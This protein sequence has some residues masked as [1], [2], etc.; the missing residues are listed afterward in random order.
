M[1][2]VFR[3]S[4]VQDQ[5]Q[6][7]WSVAE[8]R[9][10]ALSAALMRW[11]SDNV[12]CERHRCLWQG[13]QRSALGLHASKLKTARCTWDCGY[14]YAV[15]SPHCRCPPPQLHDMNCLQ[16]SPAGGTSMSSVTA[17]CKA[18][19]R[20]DAPEVSGPVSAQHSVGRPMSCFVGPSWHL[21]THRVNDTAVLWPVSAHQGQ[22]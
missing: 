8:L 12:Q 6:D 14:T 2:G 15:G 4:L 3:A 11:T 19:R 18:V 5:T 22:M 20:G 9:L 13:C 21:P 16:E 7:K 1:L 17:L 10:S